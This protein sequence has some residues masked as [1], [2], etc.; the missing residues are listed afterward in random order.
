MRS[1]QA[2]STWSGPSSRRRSY[3]TF[4]ADTT[5]RGRLTGSTPSSLGSRSSEGPWLVEHDVFASDDHVCAI[6]TIGVRRDGV[7]V[8]TRFISIFRYRDGRMVERWVYP[9]DIAA[10]DAIFAA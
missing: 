2:T 5:W 10:W 1:A 3:G 9:E 6:S 7:E 8:Q 4:P